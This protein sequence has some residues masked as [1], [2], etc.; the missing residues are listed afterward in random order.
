MSVF[1]TIPKTAPFSEEEIELAQPRG[2]AGD[3]RATRLARRL[4]GGRRS[5]V[6]PARPQPAAPARPA[7]PL[8]IVY[9][10]RV[11][12]LREARRRRREGRAQERL[13]ADGRRH[14]RSRPC[15][16]SPRAKRLVVIAATW[17]E[18]EPPARATRAYDEL[19]GEGAPRLDG[20]E[21]GVLAL[22]DTAY[23]EFCAIG[24][25]IDERLAALGGKRVVDRVDCDLDFAEPAAR[26]DRRRAE[27]AGAAGCRPR[28]SVIEVDFGGKPRGAREHRHRRGRDHRARQSQLLA[29]RQG[30]HPSRARLRRRARRPTSRATRSTSIPRTI[31]PMS[32]SCSR[33]PAL[34]ATT[35]CAPS[36]STS[37]DITTLSLKTV[38]TY[39]DVDRPSLRQGAASPTGRR[40]TGSPAA[41]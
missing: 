1:A 41:S 39:A 7:E 29:L 15:R 35:S 19:M 5:R 36:S 2:R 20:V 32:T 34:P 13:Q 8:T 28:R 37:R 3:A 18:G 17:G 14:G 27:G 25:A 16:R 26:L 9:R 6:G 33:P 38:E 10:E 4:P 21:F 40:A 12:Q 31:R 30:D 11:R 24:K 22:G 23:V